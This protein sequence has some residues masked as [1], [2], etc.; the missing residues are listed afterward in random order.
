MNTSLGSFFKRFYGDLET[1]FDFFSVNL[2]DGETLLRL[3]GLRFRGDGLL[4]YG[5]V[6]D[7]LLFVG[8]VDT[9]FLELRLSLYIYLF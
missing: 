8:L 5:L 3:E 7:G 1:E 6:F 4:F 9:P 2:F